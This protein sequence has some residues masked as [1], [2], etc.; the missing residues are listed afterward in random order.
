MRLGAGIVCLFLSAFIYMT[1]YDI[2][3]GWFDWHNVY[4]NL[5]ATVNSE[6]WI[7]MLILSVYL[8]MAFM[9]VLAFLRWSYHFALDFFRAVSNKDIHYIKDQAQTLDNSLIIDSPGLQKP[10]VR[11]VETLFSALVWLLFIYIFQVIPATFLWVFGLGRIYFFHFS[12]NAI[13]GT[14]N[15]VF[16]ILYT[17]VV[18]FI[19]LFL[20]AQWNYWRYG[21]LERRKARPIVQPKEIAAFYG[22]KQEM[23]EEMQQIKYMAIEPQKDDTFQFSYENSKLE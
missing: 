5:W 18:C 4:Q 23:V 10:A 2:S 15:G 12:P 7:V 8:F 21:Q 16:M 20:W 14:I 13:Q 9:V 22:L 19:V 6:R 3:A 17:A 11:F 1:V